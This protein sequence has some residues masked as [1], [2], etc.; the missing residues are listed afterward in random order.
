[1]TLAADEVEIQATPRPG[2][3]VA[4]DDGLVMVARHGLTP[5]LRAEGDARELAGR[6]Q[7]LRQEAG[8]ELDDRIELWVDGAPPAVAAHL[9]AVAA[10]TLA[11]DGGA[12]EVPPSRA[13]D[14]PPRG[15]DRI[16]R[17]GCGGPDDGR[18]KR[19][20]PGA[21]AAVLRHGRDS[22]SSSTS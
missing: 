1:M 19:G 5:A 22:S 11:D 10:D 17:A 15:R 3:A 20:R 14:R 12:G 4:E 7:D 18:P 9:P 16:A 21:L 6:V 2:T 8:L 13:R